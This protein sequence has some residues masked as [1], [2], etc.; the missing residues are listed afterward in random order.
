MSSSI[1][2]SEEAETLDDSRTVAELLD[3]PRWYLA[4]TLAERV[5][6]WRRHGSPRH[7]F[8]GDVAA[9]RLDRW[10]THSA[11]AKNPGLW[12]NPP[13]PAPTPHAQLFTPPA[14]TAHPH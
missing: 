11:F 5:A 10:K 8:D 1:A 12:E 2:V 6:G 14:A 4:A 7:P 13:Q 3:S 9:G